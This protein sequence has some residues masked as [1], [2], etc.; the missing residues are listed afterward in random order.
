MNR[1][2]RIVFGAVSLSI[3]VAFL[4]FG[5]IVTHPFLFDDIHLELNKQLYHLG[6][7][8]DFFTSPYHFIKSGVYRPL[9]MLSYAVNQLLFGSSIV[10]FRIFQII[11]YGLNGA[12]LFF[13]LR[14]IHF[15]FLESV[16][17]GLIFLFHPVNSELV[18]VVVFRH[19]ILVVTFGLLAILFR[20]K[21]KILG[22][23]VLFLFSL[24][25]KETGLMIMLIMLYY[26]L[27]IADDRNLNTKVFFQ[28][29]VAIK[30]D[31]LYSFATIFVYMLFRFQALQNLIFYDP[32]T[33]VQNQLRYLPFLPGI[34]TAL[35]VVGLYVAKIFYP[36]TL[37][38]DYSYK[39]IATSYS[40]F[41]P[42]TALGL[43]TLVICIFVLLPWVK[44]NYKYKI[45]ALFFL[46]PLLIVSNIFLKIGAIAAERWLYMPSAAFAILIS[47]LF[48]KLIYYLADVNR[49]MI[50]LSIIPLALLLGAYYYRDW[51]RNADWKDGFSLYKSTALASPNSVLAR[52]NLGAMYLLKKDYPRARAE[53]EE[54]TKI[55]P[56]YPELVFN[57][58]IYFQETGD[59]KRG[60]EYFLKTLA[61]APEYLNAYSRLIGIYVLKE[62]YDKAIFWAAK[63]F[64]ITKNQAD[65]DTVNFLMLKKNNRLPDAVN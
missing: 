10:S 37:S 25:S 57:W 48:S 9:P 11:L 17:A 12:L 14:K 28:R 42:L 8:S 54:A 32:T 64:E 29:L 51:K 31:I 1:E 44:L 56:D 59:A 63:K 49:K 60:E 21:G 19:D 39:Q 65:A 62:D 13:L 24:F 26:L 30:K 7:I 18:N 38:I 46:F 22:A 20:L 23:Y 41:E 2:L 4:I 50:L 40:V 45:A 36:A 33:I 16:L 47:V 5:S 35:K 6:N 52:N 53:L 15:G 27:F 43:L 61:I 3:A 58:G 55:Y 34:L